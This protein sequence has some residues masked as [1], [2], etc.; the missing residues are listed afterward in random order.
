MS[1]RETREGKKGAKRPF[2]TPFD[3]ISIQTQ[4]QMVVYSYKNRSR[5]IVGAALRKSL[6]PAQE[7]QPAARFVRISSAGSVLP[8]STSRKALPPVEM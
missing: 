1:G 6:S 8:S 7:P 5:R 3:E 4:R 2:L